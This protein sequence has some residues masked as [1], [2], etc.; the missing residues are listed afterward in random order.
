MHDETTFCNPMNGNVTFDCLNNIDV[1]EPRSEN[2]RMKTTAATFIINLDLLVRSLITRAFRHQAI[3]SRK[4]E[5]RTTVFCSPDACG[6][7]RDGF[8]EAGLVGVERNPR[9]GVCIKLT[10]LRVTPLY[11]RDLAK[12]HHDPDNN[13]SLP[14]INILRR[15]S[16]EWPHF[17]NLARKRSAR[18]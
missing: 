3:A 1:P 10:T 4:R 18:A 13:G 11:A 16:A 17:V 9:S 2:K 7:P 14:T 5:S 12:D 8:D 6:L 15:F